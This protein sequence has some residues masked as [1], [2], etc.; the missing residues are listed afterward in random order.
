MSMLP[1]LPRVTISL[2]SWNGVNLHQCS[3]SYNSTFQNQGP[4][5]DLLQSYTNFHGWMCSSASVQ[6]PL[7]GSHPIYPYRKRNYDYPQ[8]IQ[9]YDWLSVVWGVGVWLI[10][11][12]IDGK[13][14]LFYLSLPEGDHRII[15]SRKILCFHAE[16]SNVISAESRKQKW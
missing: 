7:L 1:P 6:G 2:Y 15:W 14:S 4:V 13:K 9:A 10:K 5:D 3:M 12:W 16:R 11:R 8:S